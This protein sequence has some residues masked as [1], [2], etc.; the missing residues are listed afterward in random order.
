MY[1][2][3]HKNFA[4]LNDAKAYAERL[5]RRKGVVA[6]ITAKSKHT[7]DQYG[8]HSYRNYSIEPWYHDGTKAS[9]VRSYSIYNRY[10]SMY[11]C[12]DG[13]KTIEEAVEWIDRWR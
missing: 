6:A 11:D 2:C 10:N 12:K 7:T 5:F 8:R 3:A 13:F 1:V 4:T 9:G